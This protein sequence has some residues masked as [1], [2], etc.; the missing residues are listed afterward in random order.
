MSLALGISIS[1]QR[2]DAGLPPIFGEDFMWE[3]EWAGN[4][5]LLAEGSGIDNKT[6][7]LDGTDYAPAAVGAVEAEGY[8]DLDGS[9]DIQPLTQD[10]NDAYS[11]AF[12]GTDDE[13]N[14]NGAGAVISGDLGSVSMWFKMNVAA[15]SLCLLYFEVDSNNRLLIYHHG[16]RNEFTMEHKGGGT[17]RAIIDTTTVEGNGWHHLAYTWDTAADASVLYLDGS[18]IGT[19]QAADFTGTISNVS[20][21]YR[22]NGGMYFDGKLNDVSLYDD[23]LTAGEVTAIYNNGAPTDLSSH[24]GL[25]A[26]WKFE[27]NTGTTVADS[28]SNSNVATLANGTAFTK[29]TP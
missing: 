14:A 23:V 26:Y 10:I 11:V 9:S 6:W 19:G 18:S 27:E 20:I 22:Y 2:I 25:V 1:T 7:D 29:D 8:F 3:L 21:G 17:E 4:V 13:V 16:G 15:N 24:S 5:M 12:D 28:S